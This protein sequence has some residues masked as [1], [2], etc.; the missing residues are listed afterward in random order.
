[1]ITINREELAWAAG[2]FDG[3]GNVRQTKTRSLAM[4]IS[5]ASDDGVPEVLLRFQKAV[6]GLGTIEG[7]FPRPRP[8]WRPLYCWRVTSF[9]KVQAVTAMLW[10][11]LSSIKR[12]QAR[13]VLVGVADRRIHKGT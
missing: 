5:Q 3:E 9:E 4:V 6:G 8:N 1:V 7:P 11:F 10:P 13:V 12:E 2:F